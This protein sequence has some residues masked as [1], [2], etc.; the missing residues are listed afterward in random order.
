MSNYSQAIK[1]EDASHQNFTHQSDKNVGSVSE[2]GDPFR[3]IDRRPVNRADVEISQYIGRMHS[4]AASDKEYN[5]LLDR[6]Q[7]LLDLKFSG[8]ATRRDLNMLKYVEWSLDR[9]E[10]ARDGSLDQLEAAISSYER[11]ADEID[12]LN[13]SIS[14]ARRR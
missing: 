4:A 10:I 1:F 7:S 11:F 14:Q 12:R 13:V 9:I 3:S 2:S 5:Q 6:R 8:K